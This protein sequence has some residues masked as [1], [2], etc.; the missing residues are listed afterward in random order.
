M[1]Q[2]Y[3]TIFGLFCSIFVFNPSWNKV[4]WQKLPYRE[5]TAVVKEPLPW[6]VE[7]EMLNATQC[8]LFY[9][10]FQGS[11]TTYHLI[12]YKAGPMEVR[13]SNILHGTGNG[14]YGA[15]FR[16]LASTRAQR[17]WDPWMGHCATPCYHVYL[18]SMM[19]DPYSKVKQFFL[20]MAKGQKL[21][22]SISL[23]L[24]FFIDL[25]YSVKIEN[26]E[27]C[28]QVWTNF[29]EIFVNKPC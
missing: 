14:P 1:D 23:C 13:Y 18:T 5:P 28:K 27:L 24:N 9:S 29:T 7:F 25:C 26:S 6:N 4:Y 16:L 10:N 19:V 12:S 22:F 2:P 21:S 17:I 15:L 3:L 20:E 8:E 11:L